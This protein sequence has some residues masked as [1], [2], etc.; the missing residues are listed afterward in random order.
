MAS[1]AGLA[2]FSHHPPPTTYPGEASAAR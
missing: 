1:V 2:R